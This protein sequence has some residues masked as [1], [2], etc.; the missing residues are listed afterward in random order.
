MNFGLQYYSIVSFHP[1]RGTAMTRLFTPS[2]SIGTGG[3]G[4]TLVEM[5]VVVAISG[6]LAAVAAPSLISVIE[7]NRRI[8]ISNQL[9]EDLA[10]ARRQAIALSTSVALCGSHGTNPNACIAKGASSADWSNG[11]YTYIGKSAGL[12]PAS[13][14]AG[15]VLRSPQAL[16][17]GWRVDAYLSDPGTYV[18]VDSRSK[19]NKFGHFTIY[20]SGSTSRT[21]ACVT[22]NTAGRARFSTAS[23]ATGT[24]SS[25]NDPC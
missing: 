6:I 3:R 14:A 20:R 16:P 4:F 17:S 19:T 25:T 7:S 24:V 23:V 13:A 15:L 12:S 21:A 2:R 8:T 1:F 10:L 22:V 9:M 5:L 11:W 18:Y